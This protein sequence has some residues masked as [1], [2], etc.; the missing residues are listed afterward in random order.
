MKRNF[1]RMFSDRKLT[2]TMI[3]FHREPVTIVAT[4]HMYRTSINST[5]LLHSALEPKK[6][7]HLTGKIIKERVARAACVTNFSLSLSLAK[8]NAQLILKLLQKIQIENKILKLFQKN[9]DL[10]FRQ[11]VSELRNHVKDSR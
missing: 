9:I 1:Y 2:M 7:S 3:F 8:P 5:H 10:N 6:Q 11:I 4:V